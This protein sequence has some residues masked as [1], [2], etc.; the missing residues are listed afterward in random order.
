M[1]S[2]YKKK[3]TI[4]FNFSEKHKN[5]IRKC[6]NCTF[7]IAEGA[8]RAGKTVDNVFSFAHEIKRYKGSYSPCDRIYHGKCK[9]EHWRL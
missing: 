1:K 4:H 9:A 2:K 6:E 3:K 8:V 7:N 5:Y